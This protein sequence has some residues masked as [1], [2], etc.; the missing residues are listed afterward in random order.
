MTS[1][2]GSIFSLH[3]I[4]LMVHHSK[5]ILEIVPGFSCG[6]FFI[7][8]AASTPE[9]SCGKYLGISHADFLFMANFNTFFNRAVHEILNLLQQGLHWLLGVPRL[10]H[11]F[12]VVFQVHISDAYIVEK[13]VVKHLSG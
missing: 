10:A 12:K 2:V 7:S 1:I 11:I 9:T 5:A 13:Q 4:V 3:V 8:S 6:H